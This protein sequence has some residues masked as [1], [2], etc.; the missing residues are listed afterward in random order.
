MRIII[1]SKIISL[2]HVLGGQFSIKTN[3]FSGTELQLLSLV[4]PTNPVPLGVLDVAELIP[5]IDGIN[6]VAVSNGLVAI[7]IGADPQTDPGFVAV[8]DIA[9]VAAG[10]TD[11]TVVEV[12]ALPDNIVFSPDV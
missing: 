6:S 2:Y 4:D 5:N 3:D 11:F 8:A 10:G 12:G 7:A 9:A 1:S